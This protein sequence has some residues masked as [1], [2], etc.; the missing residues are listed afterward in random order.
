MK[1]LRTWPAAKGR[2]I[3][4]RQVNMPEKANKK[5]KGGEVKQMREQKCNRGRLKVWG[6]YLTSEGTCHIDR[7]DVEARKSGSSS[8]AV[9]RLS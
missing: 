7:R 3:V 9:L 8:C 2:P 4:R 5:K 1:Y 6:R